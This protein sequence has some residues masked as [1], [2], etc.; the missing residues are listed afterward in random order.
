MIVLEGLAAL[1]PFRRDRLET[2][3]RQL[4]PNICIQ[5]A[6]HIYFVEPELGQSLDS[7]AIGRILEGCPATETLQNGRAW[8][9]CHPG[10]AK[11]PRLCAV[12]A[13]K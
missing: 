13:I 6:W 4:A 5:G 8:E 11:R 7:A 10:P 3:L 1:S 2:R 9:R 12:P